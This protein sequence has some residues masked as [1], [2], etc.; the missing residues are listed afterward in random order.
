M[1]VSLHDSAN[2]APITNGFFT[3]S[4]G[5]SWSNNGNGNYDLAIANNNWFGADSPAH[6][7]QYVNSGDGSARQIALVKDVWP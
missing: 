5:I 4:S 1:L 7:V 3:A 6:R 2:G